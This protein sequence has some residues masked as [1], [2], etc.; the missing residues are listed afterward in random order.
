[1]IPKTRAD[2]VDGV[3]PCPHVT[4]KHH[5]HTDLGT[6]LPA[7]ETCVLDIADRGGVSLEEVCDI[8]HYNSKESVRLI[9]ERAIVKIR[10]SKAGPMVALREHVDEGELEPVNRNLAKHGGHRDIVDL[11]DVEVEPEQDAAPVADSL[12]EHVWAAYL[13]ACN[14]REPLPY[15]AYLL[16]MTG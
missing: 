7:G 11:P 13:R 4:C 16:G 8:L 2:C 6:V 5:I 3:R 15:M 10:R 14:A 9:E 1:M 12:C